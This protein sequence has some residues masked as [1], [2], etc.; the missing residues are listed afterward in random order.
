AAAR[1]LVAMATVLW[2]AVPLQAEQTVTL[3]HRALGTHSPATPFQRFFSD[4]RRLAAATTATWGQVEDDLSAWGPALIFALLDRNVATDVVL[5]LA[6]PLESKGTAPT[7]MFRTLGLY[8]AKTRVP[9]THTPALKDAI[10]RNLRRIEHATHDLEALTAGPRLSPWGSIGAG[11]WLAYLELLYGEHFDLE[12]PGAGRWRADGIRIVEELL[13]RGRSPASGFRRDPRDAQLALWPTALAIYALVQAYESEQVVRYESA[14][15]AAAGATV[16]LRARNGSYFSTTAKAATDAR[17]NAYLAGA[18]LLLF[19]DTGSAV[20]RDRAVEILH[21]LTSGSGAAAAANDASLSVHTAYLALLLDSL[22]TQPFENVLGRRPMRLAVPLGQPSA[23]TVNEMA[24]R[25]R[26]VT[27]R[28]REMFDGVLHTLLERVPRSAG[29]FAYDHDDAPG[30]A[31]Q[32]LLA[33]GDTTV[34]PQIIERVQRLLAWPRRRDF[35]EMAFGAGAL[36][37]ALDHPGAIGAGRAGRSLARYVFLS[38]SLAF[39]DRYYFDWLD[40]L[41]GSRRWGGPT[42]I[43]AQITA[44][45]LRY[46]AHFPRQKVGRLFRP[47]HVGRALLAGAEQ[48]AWDGLRYVYRAAPENDRIQLLPNAMIIVDLVHA[49]ELTGDAAYL[50]R[51]ESVAAGLDA[52]WDVRHK[53]YFDAS[54]QVGAAGYRSLSGNSYAALALLRLFEA[55]RKPPYRERALKVFD[56]INGDLYAQGIAYHHL[57][58]HGRAAGDIWCSG[59]NWRLLSELVELARLP[60]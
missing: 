14:A 22:A 16:A 3:T 50:E 40:W 49:H 35:D 55:T 19:K 30:Y 33:G 46:A 48:H 12:D 52:L 56:F 45:Q 51:A 32:V 31:A 5:D 21:W 38:A 15:I 60:K 26:P 20:Y 23:Q 36:L 2:L 28:Y 10:A 42:T 58:R 8:A 44:T 47:L 29:D 6:A 25:L 43:G 9:F 57:D 4:G 37:A 17:A 39:V 59:C 34:A 27:F 53:A 24:A 41:T 7:L 54:D 18:L 11:A 1:A 13:V